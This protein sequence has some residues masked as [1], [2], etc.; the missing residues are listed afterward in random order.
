MPAAFGTTIPK[1]QLDNLV[2][3]LAAH[4]H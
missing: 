2:Q 4:T 1:A 3:Y